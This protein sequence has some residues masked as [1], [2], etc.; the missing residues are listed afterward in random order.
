MHAAKQKALEAA[1]K[2]RRT[3]AVLGGG[4]R[5]GGKSGLKDKSL[6]ELAAEVCQMTVSLSRCGP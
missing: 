6:R 4:G 5:L 2:R 1:E 3:A